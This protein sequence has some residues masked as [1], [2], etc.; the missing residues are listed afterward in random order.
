MEEEEDEEEKDED[1]DVDDDP[2]SLEEHEEQAEEYLDAQPLDDSLREAPIKKARTVMPDVIAI[3]SEEEREPPIK[4]RGPT[5]W[6]LLL[7]S[8]LGCH[9]L[10]LLHCSS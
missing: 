6:R 1:D 9:V 7:A 5:C 2:L 3:E 4:K 10:L 8:K